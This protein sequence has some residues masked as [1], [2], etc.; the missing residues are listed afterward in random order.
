MDQIDFKILKKLRANARESFGTIA[1]DLQISKAT[2]SRRVSKLESEGY[3]GGYTAVTVP[4]K[5]GLMRA[6]ISLEVVGSAIGSI[7]DELKKF[8]EIEYVYKVF[9]DH[10]LVCEVYTKSVDNLYQLIQGRILGIPNIS[11]VEVDILIERIVLNLDA[12]LNMI[13]PQTT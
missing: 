8:E 5:T 7:I 13:A 11:N 3:I 9:G 12:D 1:A 10:S 2:V 6:L 4:S